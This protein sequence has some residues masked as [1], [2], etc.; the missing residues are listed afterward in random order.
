MKIALVVPGGVD[1]SGTHR[2]I[3][4]LLWL[5]ERL[6]AVH[7][8][9]VFALRQY[10]RAL[11]YRLLGAEVHSI[12]AGLRGLR[13]LRSIWAEHRYARFDVLHAVWAAPPGVLAGV[14]GALLRTPVLLHLTGCD[15]V[16]LPEIGY[17][18]RLHARGRAWLRLATHLADRIT[19]PSAAMAAYA[20]AQGIRTE[21]L[22]YGVALD[23]W[24]ARPPAPRSG[25][26]ARLLHVGS[27]NRVKDQEMLLRAAARLHA[28]G[29]E[30]RLDIVG[31]DTLRGHVQRRAEELGLS[32]AVR[33]HGFLPHAV[34]RPLMEEAHLLLVTSRHEADP[35]IALEAAVAGVPTVGTMVGHL[36]T[37]TPEAAAAVPI[38][39]DQALAR[40]IMQLLAADGRRLRIAAAAQARALTEDADHT[41]A[42]I[43][44]IYQELATGG[45]RSAETMRISFNP[46]RE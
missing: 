43:L 18:L 22:P 19:V 27:M 31:T 38:G 12:G 9:H 10:D 36:A 21:R 46:Q 40:E 45:M 11:R 35:I 25:R 20:A 8:V 39:D 14:A 16:A 1:R 33:F 15:L 30:F 17:G 6:A 44:T 13:T 42:R 29:V 32:S 23:R 28:E 41:A 24:P 2:V 26:V 7:E 4:C 34:L 5:I 3:P 37:W